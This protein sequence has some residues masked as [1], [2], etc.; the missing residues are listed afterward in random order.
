MQWV[1]KEDFDKAM[2]KMQAQIDKLAMQKTWLQKEA[3]PKKK[4]TA[5]K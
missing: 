2:A 1:L 4:V 3:K 5:K